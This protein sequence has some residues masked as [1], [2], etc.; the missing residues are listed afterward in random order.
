VQFGAG[1][2]QTGTTVTTTI[3][4]NNHT[5]GTSTN[6]GTSVTTNT[7][8]GAAVNFQPVDISTAGAVISYNGASCFVRYSDAT[9]ETIPGATS[10]TSLNHATRNKHNADGSVTPMECPQIVGWNSTGCALFQKNPDTNAYESP[11][12]SQLVAPNSGWTVNYVMAINDSGCIVGGANYSGSNTNIVTGQHGCL[13]I[14]VQVTSVSFDGTKY[15]QLESDDATTQYSAP[16]WTDTNGNYNA[17]DPGEHN[18]A[19]AYTR[20]TKP[21]IGATFKIPG[22]SNWTNLKFK[23]TGP[24]GISIPATAGTV[25]GDGVTVTLAVTESTTALPNT[26]KFYNWADSISFTLNWSMSV[27]GGSTWTSIFTTKHTVYVTLDDPSPNTDGQH[28]EE[29]LFYLG[30]KDAN[31]VSSQT[32]LIN[33]VWTDFQSRA[34]HRVS[35]L[36]SAMTYYANSANPYSTHNGVD[37]LM[38]FGDGRCGSYQQLMMQILYDQGLPESTVKPKVVTPNTDYISQALTAYQA[39]YGV[40]PT[41]IYDQRNVRNIFFVKNW[42]LSTSTPFSPVDLPDIPAQG[43]SNPIAV[44]GDHAL[45]EINGQIYDPS[46]GDGPYSSV[47]DWQDASIDGFGVQFIDPTGL[48]ANF[49][50]YVGKLETHATQNVNYNDQ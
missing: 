3:A 38:A 33:D 23:A 48:A 29:T 39:Q 31:G 25:G 45:V 37:S 5:A 17:S 26:V 21:K 36:S 18:Y 15:W 2:N 24:D 46:Y 30:C 49:V 43:N 41:T 22:A 27:D 35:N 10:I 19:V 9:Q 12:L 14:P 42:T 6:L 47:I 32:D 8:D 13:L 20:N 7:L 34:M 4:K 11:L 28:F 50:L 16:Q 40:D 1:Y 44:F